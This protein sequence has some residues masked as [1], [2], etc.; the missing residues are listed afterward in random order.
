MAIGRIVARAWFALIPAL[1]SGC[2]QTAPG[3]PENSIQNEQQRTAPDMESSGKS[4][5]GEFH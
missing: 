3:S 1:L 4:R 2:A 5:I